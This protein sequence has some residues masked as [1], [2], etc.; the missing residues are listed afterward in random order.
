MSESFFYSVKHLSK[1]ENS[2]ISYFFYKI[3]FGVESF[4]SYE[5]CQVLYNA[6]VHALGLESHSEKVIAA[7]NQKHVKAKLL[8]LTDNDP[9]RHPFDL[10][11]KSP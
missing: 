1:D 2:I 3:C 6:L 4:C 9:E 10:Y 11:D 7:V 8:T 5:E